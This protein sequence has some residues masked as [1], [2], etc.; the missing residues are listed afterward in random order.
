MTTTVTQRTNCY[1]TRNHLSGSK[2]WM[3][4]YWDGDERDL[5]G[6][7]NIYETPLRVQW[8]GDVNGQSCPACVCLSQKTALLSLCHS[9]D[10]SSWQRCEW[11]EAALVSVQCRDRTFSSS[12]SRP[13]TQPPLVKSAVRNKDAHCFTLYLGRGTNMACTSKTRWGR[14]LHSPD[15]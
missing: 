15:T 10:I 12:C 2:R 8:S 6:W 9:K 3:N 1:N 11:V 13:T 14:P 7:N 5:N 4:R